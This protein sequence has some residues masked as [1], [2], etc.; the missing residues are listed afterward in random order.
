MASK[1]VTSVTYPPSGPVAIIVGFDDGSTAEYATRSEMAGL[2]DEV[3]SN[4]NLKKALVGRWHA[5][6]PALDDPSVI[7]GTTIET[8]PDSIL[9]PVAFGQA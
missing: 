7:V 8:N 4:N 5:L 9:N 3:F 6:N 2:W 1:T